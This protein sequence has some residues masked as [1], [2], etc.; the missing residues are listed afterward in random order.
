MSGCLS[1][2]L[3]RLHFAIDERAYR[4]VVPDVVLRR[5]VLLC[6]TDS[7][8]PSS[9]A[10]RKS[11]STDVPSMPAIDAVRLRDRFTFLL[12]ILLADTGTGF[13]TDGA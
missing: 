9:E 6:T 11:E 10:P 4:R 12:R 7:C 5:A 8:A 13:D 1:G 2:C 3:P